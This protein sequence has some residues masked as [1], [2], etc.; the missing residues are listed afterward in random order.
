MDHQ[1]QIT[2]DRETVA[3]LKLDDG[4]TDQ[5]V[6]DSEM[7]GFGFRLRSDGGPLRRSWIVQYRVKGRTRRFKI[8]AYPTIKAEKAREKAQKVLAAVVLGDDPQTEREAERLNGSRALIA[9]ANAY[10]E[11]KALQVERGQ[12]RAS[13]YRVTKLYLTGA[14]YFGPL[15]KMPITDISVADVATRINSINRNSGAISASRARAALSAMYV[16]AAQ[17]GLLGSD[18]RNPVAMTKTPDAASSRDRVLTDIEIAAIWGAC[19][20]GDDFGR[21]VRL[22]T[23][24]ACRRDEIGGLRWDEIKHEAGTIALPKERVKNKHEHT[25]P[26]TPM[27]MEI[28]RAIPQRV[29]RDHVFGDRSATGFTAWGAAKNDLDG[30]LKMA[31]WKLHD[32]RRSVATWMA[33]HGNVEPHI[34]EA[35]LNHYSGHRSGD[36]GVYNRARYSRQILVAL[37]LWH[38]HLKTLIEGGKRKVLPFPQAA[39]E[40][41]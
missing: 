15:H 14:D 3:A 18:P 9:T 37:S 23:L 38:D 7:K 26:L 25:L 32:L 35:I 34:I 11:M 6:F 33:E 2:L 1:Q 40:T 13:S 16:W 27:A 4:K 30:R 36:A 12:Y 41:A 39:H 5:I 28:V 31:P 24:T 17:Q 20:E 10:L 21:I 29:G 22:L 19:K 8:G